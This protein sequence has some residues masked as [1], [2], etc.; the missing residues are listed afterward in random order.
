MGPFKTIDSTIRR[1]MRA[2]SRISTVK[3]GPSLWD[4]PKPPTMQFA[5]DCG[6]IQTY[7]WHNLCNRCGPI[8]DHRQP[9]LPANVGPFKNL[10]GAIWAPTVGPFRAIDST[11]RQRMRAQ[12]RPSTAP[13]ACEWAHS[14]LLTAPF[15][16]ECGPRAQPRLSTSP[17]ASEWGPIQEYRAHHS[18]A[19][20]GPFKLIDSAIWI[21]TLGPFKTIDSTILR[22]M[23][24]QPRLSTSPF[25]GECGPIQE[26]RVHHSPANVGPAK[27]IDITIRR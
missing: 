24:A 9:H 4:Q 23:W 3:F 27:T 12:P 11:I 21:P 13:L 10:D 17:F 14:R 6:P 2:H 22:R 5:G 16:G 26:Y 18:L 1:R 8:Q 19:N 25:A 15:A 20:V 7:R